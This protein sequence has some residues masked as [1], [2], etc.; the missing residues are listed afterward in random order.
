[1]TINS[2]DPEDRERAIANRWA[3]AS[4]ENIALKEEI[5]RLKTALR[6]A[7]DLA[8]KGWLYN[9]KDRTFSQS[10]EQLEHIAALR[11]LA[12]DGRCKEYSS[13]SCAGSGRCMKMAGH[14]GFH[15]YGCD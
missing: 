4:Q 13:A 12:T 11:I 1:M 3:I 14:E 2:M 8:A 15:T 5:T 6:D 7:C 10:S 9:E